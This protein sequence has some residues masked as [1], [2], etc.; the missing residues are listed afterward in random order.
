LSAALASTGQDFGERCF[1]TAMLFNVRI[2]FQDEHF[3]R[4]SSFF[5]Q[6][7]NAVVV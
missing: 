1:N 7:R 5:F 6:K 4:V 3:M 2:L